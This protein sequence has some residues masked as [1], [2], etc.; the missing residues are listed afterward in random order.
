MKI[1]KRFL[2]IASF[3]FLVSCGNKAAVSEAVIEDGIIG[4]KFY[5]GNRTGLYFI[6]DKECLAIW[7]PSANGNSRSGLSTY[8]LKG[9]NLI[10]HKCDG[11]TSDLIVYNNEI[12][13]QNE[14]DEN[15]VKRAAGDSY[16]LEK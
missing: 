6:N 12:L 16:F 9:N 7:P 8:E 5:C 13:V 4:K 15:G 11:G 14:V 1:I 10:V 2:L 3:A